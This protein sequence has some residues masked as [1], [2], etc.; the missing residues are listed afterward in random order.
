MNNANLTVLLVTFL[1][2]IMLRSC[3]ILFY[4]TFW[5]SCCLYFLIFRWFCEINSGVALSVCYPKSTLNITKQ[6]SHC[7]LLLHNKQTLRDLRNVGQ[8]C[9]FFNSKQLL[10]HLK[11]SLVNLFLNMAKPS[12]NTEKQTNA[13]AKIT[14]V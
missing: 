14:K 8:N 7:F 10:F 6:Y 2:S 11:N 9:S 3:V 1:V 4:S 5:L 12:Q 13:Q